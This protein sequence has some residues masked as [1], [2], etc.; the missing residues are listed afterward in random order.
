MELYTG[1]L[2]LREYSQDDRH[3]LYKLFTEK[4]VSTYEA[5]L[6]VK[7]VS[8][9]KDYIKFHMDNA[10]SPNRT[11]YYFVIK[12][13]DTGGFA[14]SIGYSFVED[15]TINGV[16]GPVMELEYY[17]LEEHWNNGYTSEALKRVIA[18]AFENGVVKIFAQCHVDNPR[19]A[20]VMMKCGMYKSAVQPEPK[21]YNGV[22]K[23]NVRYETSITEE[24]HVQLQMAQ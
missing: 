7:S 2:M 14:G 8:D 18:F 4:F 22:M 17:L 20:N 21:A 6:Q 1:R 16:T 10:V 12:L 13:R 15:T 3:D 9:V 19:S 11:H 5:H 23:E 24:P